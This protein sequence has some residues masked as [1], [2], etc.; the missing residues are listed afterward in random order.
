MRIDKET[1][2]KLQH[3]HPSPSKQAAIIEHLENVLEVV[4]PNDPEEGSVAMNNIYEECG[5]MH[6]LSTSTIRRYW[7]SYLLLG[8]LPYE[9]KLREKKAKKKVQLAT[10]K[11]QNNCR[12]TRYFK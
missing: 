12:R 2:R 8:E 10:E 7:K 4:S 3:K 9:T 11:F 6:G 5:K 1:L